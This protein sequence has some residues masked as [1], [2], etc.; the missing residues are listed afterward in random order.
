MSK[1]L[2]RSQD[3]KLA[4]VCGGLAEYLGIDPT[5][6]RVIWLIAVLVYGSGLILYLILWLV[7][8]PASNQL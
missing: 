5:I 2:T 3:K 1:R 4:G 8:P 7:M 6:V